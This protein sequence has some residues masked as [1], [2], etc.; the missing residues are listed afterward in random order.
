MAG[1]SKIYCVG[2]LGG[3]LGA[4]GVNPIALQI[5]VGD[6]D[7]QWLEA[8]Y[9]NRSVKPLGSV[10][11][12]IPKRPDDPNALIDA[13][14]AFLPEHFANCP[15][16]TVVAEKLQRSEKLDFDRED[17]IPAE[18]PSLRREGLEAFKQLHI[19]EADLR[20]LDLT[21]WRAHD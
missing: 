9:V 21:S 18:W 8:H 11:I 7:R 6:A 1:F 3:F 2:G 20:P 4:D 16:L 13:C 15:S 12:I 17:N 19:F 5:L 10:R 14:I